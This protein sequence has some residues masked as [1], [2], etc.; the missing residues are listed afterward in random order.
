MYVR[1]CRCRGKITLKAHFFLFDV[2]H[3]RKSEI[4]AQLIMA[5]CVVSVH[6]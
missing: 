5:R 1:V 4:Y 2:E 6:E 3:L